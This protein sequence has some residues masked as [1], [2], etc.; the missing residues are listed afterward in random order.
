MYTSWSIV[1]PVIDF[2]VR[3]LCLKKYAN[4]PNGCP[5]YER[6]TGCPPYAPTIDQIIN[7]QLPVWAIWNVFDFAAHCKKMKS[8]HPNWTKRQTECCLY[9][10]PKARK[11]L[12]EKIVKFNIWYPCKQFIVMNPEGVGV[13]VT[14]T[15]KS[16]GIELEWPPI[17]KTY[18]IVLAGMSI[19]D[20]EVT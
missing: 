8:R 1:K 6:K 9:W 3:F 7:L 5:N 15:M 20:S 17:T 10:Q 4:H 14:A 12:K 18:Q 13:N 2:S 16:I 11:D 19:T